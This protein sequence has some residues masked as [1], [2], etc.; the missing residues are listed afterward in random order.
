MP[1]QRHSHLIEAIEILKSL[2][3]PEKQQSD[4]CGNVLR[5]G[6]GC[7]SWGAAMQ[8]YLKSSNCPTNNTSVEGFFTQDG[9]FHEEY[10]YGTDGNNFFSGTASPC[11]SYIIGYTQ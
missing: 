4:F 6:Q 7:P 11:G 5:L 8:N 10:F 1:A 2:G 9:V 3:L